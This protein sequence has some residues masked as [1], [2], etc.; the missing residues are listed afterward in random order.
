MS[1]KR[2]TVPKWDAA[3]K[4]ADCGDHF[5]P[6]DHGLGFKSCT[7]NVC[8]QMNQVCE[9]CLIARPGNE[10]DALWLVCPGCGSLGGGIDVGSKKPRA[11]SEHACLRCGCILICHGCKSLCV[12][13]GE[14]YCF[15]CQDDI[16]F[17]S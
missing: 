16:V 7:S 17:P 6:G 8:A 1:F 5:Q 13:E 2:Y 11:R 12:A 15:E 3:R 4:C 9:A 14:D 10:G